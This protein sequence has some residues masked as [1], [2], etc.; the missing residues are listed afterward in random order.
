MEQIK[1]FIEQQSKDLPV[2]TS[3]SFTEAEQRSGQFLS[4][5]ASI[6][7]WRHIFSSEKIRLL[8]I[9][10]G[11]YAEQM[12]L[13][14]GKTMTQDKIKAEASKEYLEAREALE[15]L[16]NDLSYL[17]AYYDIFMA[18]HIFYRQ[19]ARGDNA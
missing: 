17:K 4:A 1:K 8:S 18:A 11:V 13:G 12:S 15:Q 2:G 5:L 3:I 6:T 14:T 9:Q 10:T 16:E 7:D 19:M